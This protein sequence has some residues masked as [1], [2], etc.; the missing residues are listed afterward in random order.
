MCIVTSSIS[1][2]RAS[3]KLWHVDTFVL[4][5]ITSNE[6]YSSKHIPSPFLQSQETAVKFLKGNYSQMASVVHTHPLDR[7]VKSKGQTQMW[8]M[9]RWVNLASQDA[10]ATIISYVLPVLWS[11][12][13]QLSSVWKWIFLCEDHS[14]KLHYTRQAGTATVT[15]WGKSKAISQQLNPAGSIY[16]KMW[17]HIT[18]CEVDGIIK[19]SKRAVLNSNWHGESQK[20]YFNKIQWLQGRTLTIAFLTFSLFPPSHQYF[21][22]SYFFAVGRSW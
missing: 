3:E 7:V 9:S 12:L 10:L 14:D 5:V 8:L 20:A 4:H 22:D 1:H 21:Q 13:G 15:L 11:Y 2:K 19:K 6:D 18:A 17:L 16:Y